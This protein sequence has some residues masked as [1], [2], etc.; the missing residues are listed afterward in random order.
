M[1]KKFERLLRKLR[2]I[3]RRYRQPRIRMSLGV[4]TALLAL[5]L[6]LFFLVGLI[7]Y[8]FVLLLL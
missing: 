5:R 7:A 1:G 2:Q 3:N 8:K 6:Y 4:R